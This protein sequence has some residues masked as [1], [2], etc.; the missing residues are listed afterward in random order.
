ME[1]SV[2]DRLILSNQYQIL[3]ALAQSEYEKKEFENCQEI[4]ERGYTYFYG[5]L[6][7]PM[8]DSGN[9]GEEAAF[10]MRLLDMFRAL[11]HYK[12]HNA[13]DAEVTESRRSSFRGFDGNEEGGHYSIAR[14]IFER[15]DL[16]QES[17]RADLNT[18]HSIIRD[19]RA[20]EAVWEAQ[21]R[22]LNLS[23]DQARALINA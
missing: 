7:G 23:R 1:L 15:L 12:Q 17:H 14:F 10:V 21:G 8:D 9:D 13:D 20:M 22:P 18:H 16:F 5:R 3:A 4:V 11:D 19:Y 6:T 2:K